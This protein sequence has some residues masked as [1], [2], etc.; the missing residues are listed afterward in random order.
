P[1]WRTSPRRIASGLG[2]EGAEWR[3]VS[4]SSPSKL[5][6][7][8]RDSRPVGMS[9]AL[10]GGPPLAPLL[11]RVRAL[12]FVGLGLRAEIGPVIEPNDRVVRCIA[13]TRLVV[14]Q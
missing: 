3:H 4:P 7:I 14:G 6:K 8:T 11:H 10:L 1:A 12:P 2:W 9:F 13:D 5:T